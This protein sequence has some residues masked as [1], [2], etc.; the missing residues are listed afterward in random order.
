MW[1]TVPF[2]SSDNTNV[3]LTLP[4]ICQLSNNLDHLIM[5]KSHNILQTTYLRCQSE[6]VL[7][8]N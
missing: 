4:Y 1:E 3:K 2:L 6:V 8:W 5:Y 7:K